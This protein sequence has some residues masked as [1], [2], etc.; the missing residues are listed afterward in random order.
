MHSIPDLDQ[1]AY[2]RLI[3]YPDHS[4]WNSSTHLARID[5]GAG[6]EK[7]VVKICAAPWF[8]DLA[9]EAI[10]WLLSQACAISGPKKAGILTAPA[11]FWQE[12]LKDRYP[13]HAPK[14][15]LVRAWCASFQPNLN[16]HAWVN[17]SDSEAAYAMFKTDSGVRIAAF[18]TWLCNA[19]RHPHNVLRLSDGSWAVID[20][21]LIFNG[22]LGNWRLPKPDLSSPGYMLSQL[23]KLENAGRIKGKTQSNIRSSMVDHAN[24]HI[25]AA[26]D[27]LPYVAEALD[28][29]EPPAT[30]K[31]VLTLIVDR[32]WGFWM[33]RRLGML[34]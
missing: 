23:E 8:P 4:G 30:A 27:A 28:R 34:T 25:R 14:D 2:G 32:A 16:D 15:G 19:D 33:P 20:H 12:I 6:P 1:N 21:E 18:D 13:D 11:M 7:S 10:G 24:R 3:A 31:N 22:S 29:I 26:A 17:L 5:F 9:N